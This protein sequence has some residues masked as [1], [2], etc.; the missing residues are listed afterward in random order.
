[1][2]T[3]RFDFKEVIH[4]SLEIEAEHGVENEQKFMDMSLKDLLKHSN[5]ASDGIKREIR[6]LVTSVNDS[7][8]AEEWQY[9][10]EH[11]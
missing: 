3:Y 2:D 10:K 6:F 8:D 5:H 4:G 9:L 11:L 1:M 7:L